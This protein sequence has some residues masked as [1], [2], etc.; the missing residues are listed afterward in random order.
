M[1]D[2]ERDKGQKE[3]SF[4]IGKDESWF[5]NI[6]MIVEETLKHLSEFSHFSIEA[7]RRDRSIIDKLISDAQ[8]FDNARQTIANQSL[9]NA[10][11]TANLAGKAA[12]RHADLAVDRQWNVDE[13]ASLVAKT[14]VQ[15]DAFV[16]LL[17]SKIAE[18]LH[19]Q[20]IPKR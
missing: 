9:Q 11:E 4:E 12:L 13:V 6:K 18:A 14:G 7:A 20:D 1:G 10:V 3:R 15:L 5:A 2:G 17:A 19:E 16:T 8:Q